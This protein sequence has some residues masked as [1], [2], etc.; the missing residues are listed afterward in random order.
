MDRHPFFAWFKDKIKEVIRLP[1][2]HVY[3]NSQAI[4]DINNNFNL[5]LETY[6]RTWGGTAL[7]YLFRNYNRLL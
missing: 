5:T 4:T 2:L 3:G 1:T 7:V 6:D